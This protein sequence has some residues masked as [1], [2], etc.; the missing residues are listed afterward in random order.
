MGLDQ[1]AIFKTEKGKKTKKE[2]YWRKHSSLHGFMENIYVSRGGGDSF[3]CIPLSLTLEDI[4][5]LEE[6]VINHSLPKTAGFF[7]GNGADI[8]YYQDDLAFIKHAKKVLK[9]GGEV[10]Y[11][12][13]W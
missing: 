7:F 5:S 1:S 12:S 8:E 4:E 6:N 10:I 13:W 2:F 3:N 11:D 9:K